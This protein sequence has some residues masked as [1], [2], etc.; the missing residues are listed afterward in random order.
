MTNNSQRSGCA[1]WPIV[2][3]GGLGVGVGYLI[4]N[5]PPFSKIAANARN[6][7]SEP[8]PEIIDDRLDQQIQGLA[9][10]NS[11]LHDQ[12]DA[13]KGEVENVYERLIETDA[14]LNQ[15]EYQA[16]L[17]SQC[18]V[19]LAS[20]F[21]VLDSVS[22]DL[23]EGDLPGIATGLIASPQPLQNALM[24]WRFGTCNSAQELAKDYQEA[25]KFFL[26]GQASTSPGG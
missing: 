2:L 13:L 22:D 1:I 9:L 19:D 14:S 15:K 25:G 12:S 17:M 4:D 18:M 11:R 24:S 3:V 6:I 8:Y 7:F 16:V 23:M 26:N 20:A 10:E 21:N 5:I